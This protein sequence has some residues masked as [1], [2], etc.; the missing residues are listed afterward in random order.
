[1]A[2]NKG[3][4][5]FIRGTHY[6]TEAGVETTEVRAK[7]LQ[8]RLQILVHSALYYGM[9]ESLVSDYTW[10]KWAQELVKLQ[11]ENPTISERVDYHEAFENFDGSTGFDLPYRHPEIMTKAQYLLNIHR[12][13]ENLHGTLRN[14]TD[15]PD[16]RNDVIRLLFP[17]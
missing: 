7:I 5:P 14:Q 1:M 4:E 13:E 15:R 3:N 10:N 6:L 12:R 17:K 8:R 9:G 16:S 11:K 2:R